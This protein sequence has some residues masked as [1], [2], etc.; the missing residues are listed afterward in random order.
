MNGKNDNLGYQ[1]AHKK[2]TVQQLPRNQAAADPEMPANA[3]LLFYYVF[4]ILVFNQQP[5][6]FE[7]L[8]MS[9]SH[10]GAA[11]VDPSHDVSWTN[12]SAFLNHVRVHDE[13]GAFRFLITSVLHIQRL[14]RKGASGAD[15][16][17]CWENWLSDTASLHTI[18]ASPM[19]NLT[20]TTVSI[21]SSPIYY[22]RLVLI[23]FCLNGNLFWQKYDK[24]T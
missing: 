16:S 13:R 20:F 1:D 6:G 9:V 3:C 22:C 17:T 8:K 2:E 23:R 5:E 10:A 4:T 14:V 18:S 12:G 21:H 24:L 15:R 19:L 11:K 7:F